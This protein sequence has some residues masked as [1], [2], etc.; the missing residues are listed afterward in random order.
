RSMECTARARAALL[1]CALLTGGVATG[2]V[3]PRPAAASETVRVVVRAEPGA[4]AA[5]AQAVSD[6]GGHVLSLLTA[7]DPVAPGVPASAVANLQ[8]AG[9]VAEVPEDAPLHML[10]ATFDPATD[11]GSTYNTARGTGASDFWKAGYTGQGVDV[12]LI[13]S[14][15]VPVNGLT[16]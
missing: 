4:T 13:D 14:G 15:V 11:V 6:N 7:V 1:A 9:A 5:A 10:S 2:L 16:A 3:S 12:A 8:A